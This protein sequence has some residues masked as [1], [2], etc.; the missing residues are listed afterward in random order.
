MKFEDGAF[1]LWLHAV[2]EHPRRFQVRETITTSSSD[3]CQA[4]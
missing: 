3:L 2:M 1:F 4:H